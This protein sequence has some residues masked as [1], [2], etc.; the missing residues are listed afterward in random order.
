MIVCLYFHDYDK[1]FYNGGKIP[2]VER[3]VS[4]MAYFLGC[5]NNDYY[6]KPKKLHAWYETT[7]VFEFEDAEEGPEVCKSKMASLPSV[8]HKVVKEKK[9]KADTGKGKFISS[10]SVKC[11]RYIVFSSISYGRMGGG[12]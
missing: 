3:G 7:F 8:C 6:E 4:Q 1:L 10:P 9:L 5:T 2:P 12:N 11:S